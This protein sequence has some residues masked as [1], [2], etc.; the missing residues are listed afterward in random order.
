[1]VIYPSVQA[2]NERPHD[3]NARAIRAMTELV[4]LANA[5][6][7]TGRKKL[8]VRLLES[9]FR[10]VVDGAEA[11]YFSDAQLSVESVAELL[12]EQVI[13]ENRGL[14][15]PEPGAIALARLLRL[16]AQRKKVPRADVDRVSSSVKKALGPSDPRSTLVRKD[17]GVRLEREFRAVLDEVTLPDGASVAALELAM[18]FYEE[19]DSGFK[20]KDAEAL[21]AKLEP[22]LSAG[23]RVSESLVESLIAACD[24]H[25]RWQSPPLQPQ[26]STKAGR[27]MNPAPRVRRGSSHD[28]RSLVPFVR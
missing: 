18:R 1:M 20:R 23:E 21:A 11:G 26:G 22:T 14:R 3:G 2:L 15:V 9:L 6:A 13:H 7:D 19:H 24:R 17:A 4:E 5:G 27:A 12:F 10:L 16:V 25:G 28:L 8:L